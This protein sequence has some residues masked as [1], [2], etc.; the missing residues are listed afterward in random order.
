MKTRDKQNVYIGI[1]LFWLPSKEGDFFIRN[2]DLFYS[3]DPLNNN[4]G[5]HFLLL[6]DTEAYPTDVK[7]Q[8]QLYYYTLCND[9]YTYTSQQRQLKMNPILRFVCVVPSDLSAWKPHSVEKKPPFVSW[10]TSSVIFSACATLGEGL[11]CVTHENFD[12][13]FRG[14]NLTQLEPQWIATEKV[15]RKA[16]RLLKNRAITLLSSINSVQAYAL[17]MPQFDYLMSCFNELSYHVDTKIWE[18]AKSKIGALYVGLYFRTWYKESTL[19]HLRSPHGLLIIRKGKHFY[20][21]DYEDGRR[22]KYNRK[23]Q[24]VEV[25]DDESTALPYNSSCHI[26][27]LPK[28]CTSPLYLLSKGKKRYIGSDIEFS[29]RF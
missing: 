25:T 28:N 8:T 13:L 1:E 9:L 15:Y 4:E 23:Q 24:S 29:A 16:I 26:H 27:T 17:F 10:G 18:R 6:W 21:Y 19:R 14:R 22:L 2:P 12:E 5:T 3:F 11:K 20:L 7:I